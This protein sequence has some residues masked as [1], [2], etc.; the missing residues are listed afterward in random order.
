[1]RWATAAAILSAAVLFVSAIPALAADATTYVVQP[2]ETLY[3]IAHRFG[4]SVSALAAYNHISDPTRLSIGQILRIPAT[5]TKAVQSQKLPTKPVPTQT[6]T[7]RYT[8][9]RG[10]TLALI[11]GRYGITVQNLMRANGLQSNLIHPG[12]R[13]VIPG[14]KVTVKV[15]PLG[16]VVTAKAAT[17]TP[18]DM[19]VA[20][21]PAAITLAVGDTITTPHPLKLRR[22]PGTYFTTTALVAPQTQAQVTAESNGWMEVTLPEGD[23]GWVRREE[24]RGAPVTRPI[25]KSHTTG[26][27]IVREAMQYVGT[28]YVWGGRSAGGLDCSGL[29]YIVLSAFAPDLGRGSSYD[30]FQ[31]GVP[32]EQAELRPGDLVFFTTYAPGASHVG[33]YV[34]ER[35]FIHAAS[36]TQQ[37]AIANLD[38][39]YYVTRY[40]GA[41][42]IAT[43][44]ASVAP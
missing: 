9:S 31:M 40:I 4:V 41:R 30:Y 12:Q 23:S 25:G 38:E 39:S 2:G 37:V 32:V 20:P 6:V 7:Y 3:R 43:P 16:A 33:I 36:S 5:G 34:G 29:V 14:A 42:R 22:G 28:R 24:L 15:P 26:D 1:M 35:K 44:A 19:Q 17:G 27:A 18:P 21:E 13:L 11:A 10:D 8:V